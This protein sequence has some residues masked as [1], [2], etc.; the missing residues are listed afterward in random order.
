MKFGSWFA[1]AIIAP[2]VV[3]SAELLLRHHLN[4]E[5]TSWDDVGMALAIIT[6]LYC[7]WQLPTDIEDRVS[8][9]I[10]YVPCAFA[11][12]VYYGLIFVCSV[13]GDCL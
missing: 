11:L 12:L 1:A 7:L 13:F 10:I 5:A 3:V 8:L 4:I 2:F 6:G 9:A